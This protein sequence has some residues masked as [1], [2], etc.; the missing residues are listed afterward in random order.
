MN[1]IACNVIMVVIEANLHV[2]VMMD[3]IMILNFQ[4]AI[5]VIIIVQLVKIH[6]GIVCFVLINLSS[7]LYVI[8]VIASR[9]NYI[10]IL[11]SYHFK[12][13]KFILYI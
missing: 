5:N 10:Y 3:I 13:K 11:K 9:N 6:L 7:Y 2:Y 4:N 8:H 12:N 1:L